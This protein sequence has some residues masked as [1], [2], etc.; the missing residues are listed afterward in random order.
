MNG[1]RVRR[2]G[3]IMRVEHKG[4]ETIHAILQGA[5]STGAQ[6]RVLKEYEP[7]L[8]DIFLLIMQRLGQSAKASSDLEGV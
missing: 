6:V 4:D 8:E 2:M 3:R 7:D 5:S 1:H